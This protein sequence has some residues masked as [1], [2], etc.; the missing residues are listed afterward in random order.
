M[1]DT[2]NSMLLLSNLSL[3]KIYRTHPPTKIY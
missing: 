2:S 1:I 3:S